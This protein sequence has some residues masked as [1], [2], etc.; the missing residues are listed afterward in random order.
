MCKNLYRASNS[1]LPDC[2]W[3]QHSLLVR[4]LGVLLSW[5]KRSGLEGEHLSSSSTVVKNEWSDTSIPVCLRGMH[6]WGIKK[7]M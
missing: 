1:K 4:V 3:G 5:L 7:C 6:R 2:F